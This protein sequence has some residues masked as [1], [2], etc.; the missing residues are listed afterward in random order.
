MWQ[1]QFHVGRPPCSDPCTDRRKPKSRKTKSLWS[2][3]PR[4]VR[5]PE[6]TLAGILF[7]S[8]VCRCFLKV[9]SEGK[10]RVIFLLCWSPA[11][12]QRKDVSKGPFSPFPYLPTPPIPFWSSSLVPS[13]TKKKKKKKKATSLSRVLPSV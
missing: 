6:L 2:A 11:L 10:P 3:H 12:F 9:S 4:G 13:F 8:I 7:P 1:G 5:S